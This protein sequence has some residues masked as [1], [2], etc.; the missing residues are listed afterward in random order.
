MT[1][2]P[3]EPQIS[4]NTQRRNVNFAICSF[5]MPQL[6][7]CPTFQ[8]IKVNILP[9]SSL[10]MPDCFTI[11]CQFTPLFNLHHLIFSSL[12]FGWFISIYLSP[13]FL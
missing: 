4:N 13:F 7:L 6:L 3:Q 2:L 10:F 1:A 8:W 5:G 12:L 11:P 9:H